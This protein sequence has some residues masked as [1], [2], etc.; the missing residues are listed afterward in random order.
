MEMTRGTEGRPGE[1]DQ[2]GKCNSED[3]SSYC[4]GV[5]ERHDTYGKVTSSWA[6]QSNISCTQF[7]IHSLRHSLLIS[8]WSEDPKWKDFW[9]L[10][11]LEVNSMC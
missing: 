9:T 6:I 7:I 10:G 11:E 2:E 5:E 3:T 8:D 1:V 4:R